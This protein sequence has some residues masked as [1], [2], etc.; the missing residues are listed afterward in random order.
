MLF[1]QG[2]LGSA[3]ATYVLSGYGIGGNKRYHAIE[4]TGNAEFLSITISGNDYDYDFVVKNNIDTNAV[5]CLVLIQGD[6][7]TIS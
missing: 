7:P 5:L 6:A 4:I 3:Y 2:G 1:A